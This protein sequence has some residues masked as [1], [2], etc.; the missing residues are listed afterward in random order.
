MIDAN[1]LRAYHG[2]WVLLIMVLLLPMPIRAA[3]VELSTDASS[4]DYGI[5]LFEPAPNIEQRL[6]IHGQATFG[7]QW[8]DGFHAPYAGTNS[9]SPSSSKETVDVTLIVG[10]RLWTGAEVWVTPEIDQGFGLDNT[11]GVAGFPSGLAYKVGATDPY[12]R[13]PRAFVRQTINENG[14]TEAVEGSAGQLS[15]V[16]SLDRWVLTVGKFAVTDVF[17]TNQY[18]HDPRADFLN[19][20]I[21][22][23]GSFDYA[24]DSWGYTVG[25]ATERYTGAWTFRLGVFDL[26]NVPNSESLEHGLHEFQID[27]EI[28]RRYQLFGQT[29]RL[30]ITAFNSRGRMALLADA[31]DLAI[32]TGTTPNPAAVR[33]YRSRPGI[34]MN[35]EQPITSDFGVFLR[36]GE[37]DG[38]VEA[39]EFTDVD[40]T[41]ALGGSLRGT[42][43]RRPDDTV[44]AG[45]IDNGISAVREEYLNLGGLGILVG[46]GKLPHPGAEQGF[47]TYYSLSLLSWLHV[48]LDYQWIKYPAYNRD[49]GP[50]SIFGLRVHGQ[51]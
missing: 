27:A 44:G 31:I 20:A 5:E 7:Q 11:L 32:A 26:S 14:L 34:S 37:A 51:F 2:E 43:W 36:A 45:F 3:A 46:D 21:V 41:V 23:T 15:G 49:R 8:T 24:A 47:E 28:E 13:L 48:S 29:G 33:Q 50:V 22:D 38:N 35:V 40:R 17:D 16:H 19:W 42:R 1:D 39:Y 25:L 10:A 30:M 18:A 12:F 6:A 4:G 9:L